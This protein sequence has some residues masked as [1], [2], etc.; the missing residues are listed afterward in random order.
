MSE[1]KRP[2]GRPR[3][4]RECNMKIDLRKTAIE[5]VDWIRLQTE[6]GGGFL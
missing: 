2:L 3:C 1:E 4:K 5:I 6:I